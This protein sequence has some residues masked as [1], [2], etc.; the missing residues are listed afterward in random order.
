MKFDIEINHPDTQELDG[1]DA[2]AALFAKLGYNTDV[3]IKQAPENLGITAEG[4]LR[5]IKRVELVADQEGFLQVYLFEVAGVTV[6]HTRALVRAFRERRGN[7]LL[8]LTSDY[9]RIDF[10]LAERFI[11]P[12]S[13]HPK[14]ITQQQ[15][16]I[17]PRVLTVNRRHP[18]K[19]DL[20]VLRRFTYTEDDAYAQYDK[21]VAAYGI[22]D[23]SEEHF[24]NRA[25]FSD[26]FL[27]ERLPEQ[28]TWK[29]DP[30]PAYEQLMSIY[31]GVSMRVAG[32]PVDVHEKELIEPAL[33]VLG[34]DFKK[35]KA[36][37]RTQGEPDYRLL[38]PENGNK[39]VGV[40]LVYP[41][42]RYLD[43]KDYS[44][45]SVTQEENPGA[46]VVS[47][48]E[49]GDAPWAVVTNGRIWRLYSGKAHSRST[50]YYEIDV[51]EL[52]SQQGPHAGGPGEA[53]R[54][55]W[56]LF[57]RQSFEPT[58]TVRDGKEVE[59]SFLDELL[60]D[61]V[62]YAKKLG[63]RLKERV[64]EE[65]F[66]HIA[67]GF[68]A[69][70]K[71][72]DGMDADLSQDALNSVFQ[73]TLTLLYRILF[74][75]YAEA[76]DLL[77][78]KE[79]RGYFE[80]SLKQVKEEVARDAGDIQ[81]EAEANLK[82]SYPA[83]SFDLYGRLLNLFRMIDHGDSK[84]N[85][86]F[87]NGGLFL[88][89]PSE[90]DQTPE[91]VNARF[92]TSTKLGDR[93]LARALDLLARDLDDKRKDLAF[94]DYKSLGVRQ[95]GSI[96]EG[97]LEFK[98]RIATEKMAVVKGKRT[99]EIIPYRE[100][101]SGKKQ[102]VTEGR[103]KDATEKTLPKGAVYL[104]NDKRERKA[105][106][107]Y[108]APDH[109]VQYIVENAV[110]PVLLEKLEGL[111]PKLREA[112]RHH[113][114][115]FKR[116]EALKKKGFKPEPSSKA[117]LI[118]QELVKEFFDITVCDPAMGSGHF[119]V[120]AVDFI[121]DKTL[122]FL[123]SFPWNPVLVHLDKMRADIMSEMERQGITIDAGR[124][125]DV[126]LLKRHV[127]KRCIYGVDLNP[128]AVEL[129]KVSLWLDCFTLGAPLS[130]LDHHM[131]SGNSLIGVTV[132]EAQNA[133][134]K[135]QYVLWG[136]HFT[137]VQLAAESM[138]E[139]GELSDLTIDQVKESRSKY[140]GASTRLAPY[141]R[142]LDVYSSQWFGNN[143]T[144]TKRGRGGTIQNPA[145]DFLKSDE[146]AKFVNDPDN[147]D[148]LSD[149]WRDVAERTVAT[150]QDRRFFH[151]EL[152][153]PEIFYEKGTR[154]AEAGFDVV[155]GNPPYDVLAEKEIGHDISQE[156]D[157][158]K[159]VSVFEPAIR[160]KNNLYKL[161]ICRGVDLMAPSRSAFAYIVPMALL[162]D[163]QAAGVRDLLF[164]KAG[165]RLI[166]AFPQKDD[167]QKRVFTDAKLST[168]VFVTGSTTGDGPFQVR[169][170][171][172]GTIEPS[173]HSLT[174]KPS[175]LLAR[176]S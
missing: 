9:E 13:T 23:W 125:T 51:E 92:L 61:S 72:R 176:V 130:F 129:A 74:L 131:K 124:L 44:R 46:T 114:E 136:S 144:R 123:N 50:N 70:I 94:I 150:L 29:E 83:K 43:G 91:A 4:T 65:I 48:L 28:P 137:G 12:K 110:G 84:L 86:P 159:A 17:R 98:L 171:P 145:I 140:S 54:Y 8:V 104:E 169:T 153:F 25:L 139:I 57:R 42:G 56:L 117:D 39:T 30:K 97:L 90:D 102:I 15:A 27:M 113:K 68:I 152:E 149:T 32:K 158:F 34:F 105:T 40:A 100:A 108:Y 63:E 31:Q 89:D 88:S 120:E 33:K 10:V 5:P 142:I 75:L 95:L 119:L 132:E 49:Q 2:I 81:D 157:Y 41:W 96:Y 79:V 62:D 1:A 16:G 127:L 164:R 155:I 24:N 52:L 78:A 126:N 141:K 71:E 60:G 173:S 87:Y 6:S 22:A 76:R 175:Q 80:V 7:Y 107:S 47:L 165:P 93:S 103:G 37:D 73:G 133:V 59:A 115:F 134:E 168:V 174:L 82:K 45:D 69:Y 19:V 109:I 166:E 128:M 167:P 20:R 170:H 38:T 138:R 111:R 151:W 64:F 58:V 21:L 106:G 67:D 147:L 135:G 11:P 146:A 14:G 160:G 99:E 66:P 26:Y 163:D 55:F 112:D 172:A 122:D 148:R 3:R 116:E 18:T 77:P 35:I 53:F 143:P 161:F 162:G 118:G 85:V 156:I 154:K 36:P 101:K 121:T